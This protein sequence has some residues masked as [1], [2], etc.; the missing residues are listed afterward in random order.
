MNF[1]FPRLLYRKYSINIIISKILPSGSS[2]R[3]VGSIG[4][5]I[6]AN[7]VK[8][9]WSLEAYNMTF[10]FIPSIIYNT[11]GTYQHG[12]TDHTCIR[13]PHFL[14]YLLSY[15]HIVTHVRRHH[16]WWLHFPLTGGPSLSSVYRL[17]LSILT[18]LSSIQKILINIIFILMERVISMPIAYLPFP[19]LRPK[20]LVSFFPKVR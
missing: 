9:F 12:A 4:G 8:A 20:A 15:K 14:E 7:P 10:L 2:G 1:P 17:K 18:L 3:G 6:I 16:I 11:M 19:S 13:I 5:G